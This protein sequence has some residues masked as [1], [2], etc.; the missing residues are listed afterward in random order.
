MD[1]LD[2]LVL[3]RWQFGLTTVYHYLFVPLTIGMATVTAIF[4]TVWV[5]TGKIEYL[6]LTRF[7]AKI[8]LINFAMGV[9]TGIVQ[10]F[11]FGMNWSD[12]SRFVGDVFGAPLAFE[13]LLAFFLEATFI[14]LWIFGW[15][16]LP[17]KVHL[18][19]IW[20][21]AIGTILSAY[22]I[23]A[24]NAFMQN[25]VGYTYN[26][27]T[28]RAELTDFWA[29]LTNKVALAAF[30]HTIFGALMFATG[31]VISVSAWHISR[32]QHVDTLRPALKFGLWGML[33]ATAGVVLSGDQLGLAMVSTQPMKMAAAE[34]MF[35]SS[36]GADASFSLFS[37][38]TPDGTGEI[39][40]L[41]VPYLLAFLSTH[42][43]NGCVE[44]INDLNAQ[45][46]QQFASTGLTEFTPVLWIT[47]WAFRWMIGL[48]M[49]HAF[50][51]LVG[52][53]ITR[54]GAKKPPA[55]WMWKIAI[56]SF[57]LALGAN[58]VGWVFTEM[59][60]QPW[61]VFSLMTTKNGVS[62]GVSGVEVLISLIAFT[63][64]Y[65]SLAVVEVG[66]IVRAAKK[67]PDTT[68]K[69]DEDAPV[70]SVVY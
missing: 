47:Y 5:R 51:A 42:D 43:L 54:K 56:W 10:E 31:V 53:W 44:G 64:I 49:L 29:L 21:T 30:P 59:G 65:A 41:R 67:G 15:D 66:L 17:K 11:Q 27:A 7:F 35:N 45:Y 12:Y 19:T 40:S 23:I 48:G 50:I 62:P 14:G 1:W 37:I 25:P 16:K 20:G 3:S 33:V 68:E 36:C 32:G 63:L 8:F 13:G 9:V 38:G 61:I 55:P 18:A 58:I 4:Q 39:W 70:P 24:A 69:H 46:A 34:A 60:R 57:P 26:A 52:L 22:F 28:N 2:P 6:H